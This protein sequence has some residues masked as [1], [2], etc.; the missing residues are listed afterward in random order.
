MSSPI[1]SFSKLSLY[2]HQ[3]QSSRDQAHLSPGE[4]G[5]QP[6]VPYDDPSQQYPQ[7]EGEEDD[8]QEIESDHVLALYHCRQ[9]GTD[10]DDPSDLRYAF[11][12]AD[13]K[14]SRYG[15]RIWARNTDFPECSCGEESPC[16]HVDWLLDQLGR[17]G[18][19]I[20]AEAGYYGQITSV[21]LRT[22]CENLNWEL[23]D[24]TEYDGGETNWEL[25][26]SY[27][28]SRHI[29][30]TRAKRR[31][32]VKEVQDILAALSNQPTDDYR[33]DIFD[34]PDNIPME[35]ILAINDLG[36]TVSRLLIVDDNLFYQFRTLV[37]P[38]IRALDYFRKMGLKAKA[39]CRL[40]DEYVQT[41]P[42]PGQETQHDLIW[43]AQTLA[44]V[45]DAISINLTSRQQLSLAARTEAAK[46]LV[47]ILLDVVKKRNTDVYQ[48]DRFPRRRQHGEP[49]INRNLYERLIGSQSPDNPPGSAFVIK[50]LRTLPEASLFVEDLEEIYHILGTK[51]WGPAPQAY[52]D[53]LSD[54]IT[55]LKGSAP[56]SVSPTKRPGSSM[57]RKGKKRMK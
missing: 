3:M 42:T 54:L 11:A 2:S 14:I 23:Q 4:K 39:T 17:T 18:V 38:N 35:D 27:G 40:L 41:G 25:R 52:R 5:K 1:S 33:R 53:R 49:H 30:S 22:I 28:L 26:K 56:S 32:R 15:V 34:Y 9:I 19:E 12:I 44:Q 21:G 55:Q 51:G 7:E 45:V 36:A 43:C 24:N 16:R 29:S 31:E 47:S 37:P 8:T 50:A 13:A 20:T 57:E 10:A 6:E 48:D 46:A